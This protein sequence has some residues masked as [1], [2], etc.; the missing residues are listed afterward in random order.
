MPSLLP[1]KSLVVFFNASRRKY[2]SVV[3]PRK[4]CLRKGK[5]QSTEENEIVL[6]DELWMAIFD[7][8]SPFDILRLRRVNRQLRNVAQQRLDSLIYFDVVKCDLGEIMH[9]EHDNDGEFFRHRKSNLLLHMD[10]RSIILAVADRWS[11]R[12]VYTLWAAIQMFSAYVRC[13]TVDV[14]VAELICAALSNAKLSRWHAFQCYIQALGLPAADNMH[15][16]PSHKPIMARPTLFPRLKELT[17]R[18]PSGDLPHLARMSDYGIL[19]QSLYLEEQLELLRVN[20]IEPRSKCAR[21]EGAPLRGIKRPHQ[22]LKAF[23]SWVNAAELKEKYV[24]Q[25]TT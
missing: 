15:M 24:Q 2:D 3:Q 19:P 4:K 6:T 8:V 18:T 10:Q 7:R 20:V 13:F 22:H 16:K 21:L 12:D 5:K 25:Y 23:K 9:E 11:S 14:H 1:L 17:V